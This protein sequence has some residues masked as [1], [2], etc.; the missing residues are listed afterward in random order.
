MTKHLINGKPYEKEKPLDDK[1]III[2]DWILEKE[3]LPTGVWNHNKGNLGGYISDFKA[4]QK[5]YRVIGTQKQIRQWSDKQ[6][7]I[8]D[9]VYTYEP[10]D[11]KKYYDDLKFYTEL[12][13][14]NENE[15]LILRTN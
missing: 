3:Y 12:Y 7:F 11:E 1:K 14:D 10:S 4:A 8:L 5:S 13:K 6:T 15:L 2:Q 9:E